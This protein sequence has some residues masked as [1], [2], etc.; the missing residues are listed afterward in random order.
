MILRIGL[1]GAKFFGTVEGRR[2]G[3]FMDQLCFL[4][5]DEDVALLMLNLIWE[6]GKF[7]VKNSCKWNHGVSTPK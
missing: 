3:I 6:S 1:L 2:R 5:L 4:T 7:I